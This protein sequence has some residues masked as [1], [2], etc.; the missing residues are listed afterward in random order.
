ML[1]LSRPA[2]ALLTLVVIGLSGCGGMSARERE[3]CYYREFD[4]SLWQISSRAYDQG[5]LGTRADV[6]AWLKKEHH[7]SFFGADG[8]ILPLDKMTK[9]QRLAWGF[10]VN[11]GEVARPTRPERRA[12]VLAARKECHYGA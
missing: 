2:S 8:H 9:F 12:A 4:Q 7:Q 11:T 1:R 5:R 3:Q 6:E 10:W